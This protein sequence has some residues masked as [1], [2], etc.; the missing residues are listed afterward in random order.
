MARRNKKTKKPDVIEM[1]SWT[2]IRSVLPKNDIPLS[3]ADIKK[4]RA[5][6]RKKKVDHE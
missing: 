5:H 4:A 1:E 6:L 2:L 3:K